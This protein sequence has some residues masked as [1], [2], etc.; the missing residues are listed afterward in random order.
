MY[1]SV[2]TITNGNKRITFEIESEGLYKIHCSSGLC[3]EV[4]DMICQICI[5]DDYFIIETEDRDFRNGIR[6]VPFRK[7]DRSENNVLAFDSKGNF[8][9]N[10]GSI[11]GDIKLAFDNIYCIFKSEA[12]DVFGIT[13]PD[14]PDVLL[15]CTAAGWTFII[16]I[17]K[18]K[19]LRKIGG[20]V[21]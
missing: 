16:D 7:D 15:H 13:Q 20:M 18:R 4:P 2:H 6:P 11:V 19:L 5:L 17:E 10:I 12:K 3:I 21:R 8:L 14:I 1:I 9:W